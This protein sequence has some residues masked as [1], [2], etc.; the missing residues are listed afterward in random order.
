[1]I[2]A[3]TT[4]LGD[5]VSN[6]VGDDGRVETIMPIGADPHDFEAS[7]Q[8]AALI[9]EA[10]LVI[11][12]GLGLEEGLVDLIASAEG[13]GA[14]VLELAPLLDPLPFAGD[15]GHDEDGDEAA[16]PEDDHGD[17]DPHFWQDPVRMAEAVRL[18]AQRLAELQIANPAR[19]WSQRAE[20]YA[21]EIMDAHAANES[22]LATVP[23]ERRKLVT[24]HEAFGYF[25]DRYRFE[26]IAVVVP[27]GSTLAAPSAGDLADLVEEMKHEGMRAIFAE[28]TNPTALAEAVAAELDEQVTV[29]QLYTDSLGE[30]GSAAS[31]YIGL[32]TENARL[33]TEAL[34]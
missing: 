25:A 34:S 16:E 4:I 31:T 24:N 30:A 1:M 9:R 29:V 7:A 6:L 5:V 22:V 18:I 23:I 8:Q 3:T 17:D 21:A 27:G 20:T 15:H 33:V 13:E 26:V 2:V 28:N 12:N 11:A 19:D 10:D 32:I 14:N